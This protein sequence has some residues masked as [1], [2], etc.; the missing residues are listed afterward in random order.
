MGVGHLLA[1]WLLQVILPFSDLVASS[2]IFYSKKNMIMHRQCLAYGDTQYVLK[3]RQIGKK[4]GPRLSS[5]EMPSKKD[6]L[7]CWLKTIKHVQCMFLGIPHQAIF[8]PNSGTT[9]M[10]QDFSV[11]QK[12][13]RSEWSWTELGGR[14]V[15]WI[16]SLS[17]VS[18]PAIQS[19]STVVKHQ[20]WAVG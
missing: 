20:E 11:A 12:T 14:L 8:L 9:Q 18:G 6:W 19:D 4:L 1:I 5:F 10:Q 7:F 2:I 15:P 16:L 13:K 17:C 3:Q